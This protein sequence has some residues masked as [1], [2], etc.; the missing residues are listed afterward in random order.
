MF[1]YSVTTSVFTQLHILL[2]HTFLLYNSYLYSLIVLAS[3]QLQM[4]TQPLLSISFTYPFTIQHCTQFLGTAPLCSSSSFIQLFLTL[5]HTHILLLCQ[6]FILYSLTLTYPFSH[7]SFM[8]LLHLSY[9]SLPQQPSINTAAPALLP[10]NFTSLLFALF[11]CPHSE[12][13][14]FFHLFLNTVPYET[15]ILFYFIY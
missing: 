6:S 14:D 12:T 5:I 9:F 11:L 8:P 15:F 10:L 3:T 1:Q 13:L 7:T 2:L 4:Y